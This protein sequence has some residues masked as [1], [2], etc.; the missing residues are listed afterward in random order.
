MGVTDVDRV[1]ANTLLCGF[2]ACAVCLP[3]DHRMYGLPEN[4]ST[5]SRVQLL[6][7]F[8]ECDLAEP[9]TCV[10]EDEYHTHNLF[11]GR[12]LQRVVPM[13]QRVLSYEVTMVVVLSG[14]RP[15]CILVCSFY[16]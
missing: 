1:D 3:S 2:S 11:Q 4:L 15:P 5:Q 7:F 10:Q 9:P 6:P 12:R 13:L 8:I 14:V 16:Y